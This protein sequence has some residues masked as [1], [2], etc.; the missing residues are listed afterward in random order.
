MCTTFDIDF[1]Y[2]ARLYTN[3]IKSMGLLIHA[4]L[5]LIDVGSGVFT[6]SSHATNGSL[7]R[8]FVHV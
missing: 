5:V 3:M 7:T 4:P 8:L 6:I 2:S 1:S